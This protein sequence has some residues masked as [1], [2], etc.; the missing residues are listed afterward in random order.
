MKT[1]VALGW[2]EM[3]LGS[4]WA[5][6]AASHALDERHTIHGVLLSFGLGLAVAALG[7]GTA[8]GGRTPAT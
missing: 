4:A 6:A 3:L 1:T 7:L 8:I 5:I 2:I